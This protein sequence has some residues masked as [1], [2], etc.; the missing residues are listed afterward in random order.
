MYR[1]AGV[2][3]VCR[4]G[5]D[6]LAKLVDALTKLEVDAAGNVARDNDTHPGGYWFAITD[7][8]DPCMFT[9]IS[10]HSSLIYTAEP[11]R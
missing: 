4:I 3:A 2:S 11:L 1:L 7:K 5:D 6:L 10:N 8:T 9:S